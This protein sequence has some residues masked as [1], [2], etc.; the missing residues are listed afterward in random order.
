MAQFMVLNFTS[1]LPI[2]PNIFFIPLW[3]IWAH[4]CAI[5]YTSYD[6]SNSEQQ[7]IKKNEKQKFPER[8]KKVEDPLP[9]YV[10][11]TYLCIINDTKNENRP[12][13]C[14]V[15]ARSEIVSADIEKTFFPLYFLL[16]TARRGRFCMQTRRR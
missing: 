10:Y 1:S 6:W 2:L 7:P 4:A 8:K 9:T 13:V 16:M 5:T 14:L 12:H 11:E 15:N 3:N